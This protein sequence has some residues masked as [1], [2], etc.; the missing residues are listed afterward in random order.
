MVKVNINDK[1][2]MQA[3]MLIFVH[4]RAIVGVKFLNVTIQENRNKLK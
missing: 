4:Q 1:Q 3:R 2:I